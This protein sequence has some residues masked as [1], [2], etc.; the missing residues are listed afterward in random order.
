MNDDRITNPLITLK[1]NANDVLTMR[2][3][4][5]GGY[6]APFTR[7]P[8]AVR[9][10]VLEGFVSVEAARSAYGVVLRGA[11]SIVDLAATESLRSGTQ[12]N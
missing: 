11:E 3:P 4:G 6:H 9:N 1:L 12:T 10:D 7:D 2:L 8:N 5:G